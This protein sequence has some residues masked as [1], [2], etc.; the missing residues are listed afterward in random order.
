MKAAKQAAKIPLTV[1]LTQNVTDMVEIAQAA[2]EAGAD[3]LTIENGIC[4]F[5]GVN[6]ETGKPHLCAYGGYTGPAV[7]PIMMR[8]LSEVVRSVVIPISAVGG[9]NNYTDVIEYIILG[10]TTVQVCTAV[11][12]NDY[13]IITRII[14]DL[15]DWMNRKGYESFDQIRGIVLKEI[16][17]VE[18]VATYPARHAAIS[19]ERCT[20]CGL[21]QRVCMYRAVSEKRGA[22]WADPKQCDGCGVCQQMCPSKAIVLEE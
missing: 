7:K 16:T 11:I 1:K 3:G 20:N 2:K 15:H 17:S 22:R 8:H 12:W 18:K 14:N 19:R 10:A 9:V 6:I 21:C 13:E 4:A 5:A